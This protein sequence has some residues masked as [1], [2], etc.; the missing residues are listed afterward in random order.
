MKFLRSCFGVCWD[1]PSEVE[2]KPLCLISPVSKGHTITGGP[3]WLWAQNILHVSVL[4][5]L[6]YWVICKAV[7]RLLYG[8]CCRLRNKSHHEGPLIWE[9][10]CLL[11]GKQIFYFGKSLQACCYI[12]QRMNIQ[13][14]DTS[15]KSY[16][17]RACLVSSIPSSK[18]VVLSRI[19]TSWRYWKHLCIAHG[20]GSFSRGTSHNSTPMFHS[21]GV[22]HASG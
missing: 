12:W 7:L 11:F 10:N 9:L 18:E 3:L 6:L 2:D 17:C 14:L 21:W 1:V 8:T 22:P 13:V 16:L 4:F 5:R 15:D 20:K 19:G